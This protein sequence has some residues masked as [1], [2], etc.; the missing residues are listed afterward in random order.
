[1]KELT[2]YLTQK[3]EKTVD[4]S[5]LDKRI[6]TFIAACSQT[7]TNTF[8]RVHGGFGNAPKFPRPSELHALLGN[9]LR[10]QVRH[11]AESKRMLTATHF[12]NENSPEEAEEMLKMVEWTLLKM[13][14]GGIH[15]HVGGGFHRYSVD[16]LWHVPHFE[17]MLYDN[18]Q[19]AIVCL[20]MFQITKESKWASIACGI[21]DYLKRDMQD[22]LGGIYSAE[23]HHHLSFICAFWAS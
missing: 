11:T 7:L 16:E 9:Y 23:V 4:V 17:K 22:P 6:D 14:N 2:K 5:D 18:P 3:E 8:D 21:L 10:L 12:Q 15:D 20:H 19:I 1:M 13:S